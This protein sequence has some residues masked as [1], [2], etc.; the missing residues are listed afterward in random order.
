MNKSEENI[1][2]TFL[3][4]SDPLDALSDILLNFPPA[5][6]PYIRLL[7]A[8]LHRAILDSDPITKERRNHRINADAWLAARN[9][10]NPEPFSFH[11]ICI[12][13]NLDP[14]KINTNIKKR[15]SGK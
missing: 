4:D 10:T 14:D 3:K 2:S 5:T 8:I 15:M 6:T 13:L 11:W 7:V 1:I 12:N 9:P